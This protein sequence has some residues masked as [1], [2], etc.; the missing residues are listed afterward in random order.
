MSGTASSDSSTLQSQIQSSF[1]QQTGLSGVT[2]NVTD[3]TISLSGTVETGKEKQTAK[4]IAQ[5]YAGSRKVEDN[6]T[7]TGKGHGGMSGMS[8]SMG[9]SSTGSSST[10]DTGTST[11]SPSSSSTP[12]NSTTPKSNDQSQPPTTPQQ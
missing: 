11:T 8:G 1:Q 3:N 9:S 2:A 12:D 7:V 5:S 10:S 4:R 6:I